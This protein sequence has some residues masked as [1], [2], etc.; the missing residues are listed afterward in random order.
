M[1]T[2]PLIFDE[3]QVPLTILGGHETITN[4][5]LPLAV[6]LLNVG[7]GGLYRGKI[8]ENLIKS[9]FSRIVSIDKTPGKYN[10]EEMIRSFPSVKF[11]I[12]QEEISIGD[13][14]NLAMG[15]I[16]ESYTL[17]ITDSIHVSPAMLS[18][19]VIERYTIQGY[20]CLAPKLVDPQ[21]RPLPVR[22]SPEIEHSILKPSFSDIISDK[23][24]TLYPFDFIGIYNREKFI[25]LGGYDYTITSPYWQNL[26]FALRAWLWGEEIIMSPLFQ[27]SYESEVPV[28]DTTPDHTQ[29]RFYLK[30]GAPRYV[31]GRC[32]IPFSSF[33][34][35]RK[36]S[37]LPFLLAYREFMEARQ[38]VAKN[39]RIF[40][41][42]L[43][44]LIDSWGSKIQ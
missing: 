17:V 11:M 32:Y 44:G 35:Y 2:I 1:N 10:V 22:F 24:P 29:L 28:Q 14:I 15:E 30:N 6:I 42:D 8:L 31:D 18:A 37:K 7:A 5:R 41:Q 19:N 16:T 34:S 13:M 36:R 23:S 3:H 20:F 43:I 4:P 21:R 40:Q 27:L 38:W 12:P 39:K 33:I 25:K 9:G 26:D